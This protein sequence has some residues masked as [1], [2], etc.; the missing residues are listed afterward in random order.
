MAKLLRSIQYSGPEY[1]DQYAKSDAMIEI[2]I[3]EYGTTI[4][5]LFHGCT[6]GGVKFARP[7]V[8]TMSRSRR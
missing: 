7:L 6:G 2:R 5:K 1:W 3:P 4:H 8:K